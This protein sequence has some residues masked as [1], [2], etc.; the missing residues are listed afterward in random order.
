VRQAVADFLSWSVSRP[1]RNPGVEVNI[2]KRRK[3]VEQCFEER[4]DELVRIAR[5]LLQSKPGT[6]H[7]VED[8]LNET[9]ISAITTLMNKPY[10]RPR[11]VMPWLLQILRRRYQDSLR[12]QRRGSDQLHRLTSELDFEDELVE[13]FR[14]SHERGWA[15]ERLTRLGRVLDQSDM[16]IFQRLSEGIDDAAIAEELGMTVQAVQTKKSRARKKGIE[17][18]SEAGLY[19]E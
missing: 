11:R 13:W 3:A 17:A 10:T 15:D 19:H 12:R 1:Q 5:W 18:L 9:Y 8:L 14:I 7:E 16:L 4:H 6:D 2:D